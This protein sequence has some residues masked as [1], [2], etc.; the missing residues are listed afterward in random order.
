M[1]G[2]FKRSRNFSKPYNARTGIMA[3]LYENIEKLC[4]Q[5]GVNVTTMC[6]ESGAS[7]GSLTDLKNGR[8]QTLKY[9][10]LDKIAS[11]FETSV[12]ALV[13]GN[14]KETPPQQPQSEVDAAVE[15]IRKKLESMPKEQREALM[16]LIEKM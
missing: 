7:R 12:D 10:T 3:N 6:K 2:L 4:K 1:Q 8:K 15:R 13:S 5:R 14:Q 11:Y 9:E 16:N